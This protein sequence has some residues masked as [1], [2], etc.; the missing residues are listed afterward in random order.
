MATWKGAGEWRREAGR[1]THRTPGGEQ[2]KVMGAGLGPQEE[3]HDK[4]VEE[5]Q[6]GQEEQEGQKFRARS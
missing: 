4:P 3:G 2:G 1:S 5:G 6:E